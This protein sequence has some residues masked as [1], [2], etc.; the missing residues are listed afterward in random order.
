VNN[1]TASMQDA[2]GL[3]VT[4]LG[5]EVGLAEVGW[6]VTGWVLGDL[7]G[8]C[9]GDTLGESVVG[10]AVIGWALGD[11]DGSCEGVII[12]LLEGDRDG[13]SVVG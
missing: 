4:K 5:L 7:D 1:G 3:E 11:L 6:A 13:S 10:S 2:V 9:E 12:G 8:P